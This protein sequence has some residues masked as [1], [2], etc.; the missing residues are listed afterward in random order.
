[1]KTICFD[2]TGTLT[3]KNKIKLDRVYQ[4][5]DQQKIINITN[6]VADQSQIIGLFGCCN[7]V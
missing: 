5:A 6:T 4:I 1:M 3:Q 7:S 2:K